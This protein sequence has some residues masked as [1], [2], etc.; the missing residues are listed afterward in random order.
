MDLLLADTRATQK[1]YF[2]RNSPVR[3]LSRNNQDG[4]MKNGTQSSLIFLELLVILLLAACSSS[5]ATN[6]PQNLAS[7]SPQPQAIPVVSHTRILFSAFLG[8]PAS[9]NFEI[10]SINSD[11]S[12]LENLSNHEGRDMYPAWSPDG[13]TILFCSD[14]Q[15]KSEVFSMNVDGTNQHR[16]T[17]AITDCGLPSWS[18]PL[19]SP[20]GNWIAI[21]SSPGAAY[22]DGKLDIFLIS[23]DGSKVINLTNH[24]A[25]DS[26]YSWSPDGTYIAFNSDRDG[27]IEIYVI[28][29]DDR[30]ITRLTN[31]P[32]RDGAPAWSPDGKSIVFISDRDGNS[33]IYL[34]NGDGLSQTRLTNN[35]AADISPIW[36]ADGKYIYFTSARDGNTEVYRMNVDGSGQTNL[37]SSPAHDYWFWLSP[38][39]SKFAVSACLDKC[40]SSEAQWNTSVMNSDGTGQKI[41][42][43]AA[44]SLAWHP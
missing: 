21:S 2:H 24:P 8:D 31:N 35:P 19:W 22:P 13:K 40:Q 26:G 41:I 37:T 32:A 39:G 9:G 3:Y 11:G 20:D 30:G 43:D 17:D 44:A 6:I 5:T 15:G 29:I 4:P 10:Y 7:S 33:E 36:S 18:V 14:R 42:L 27:N 23:S 38:D 1:R 25:D 12:G 28:N 34:M 16:L